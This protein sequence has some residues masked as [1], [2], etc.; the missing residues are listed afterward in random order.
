M[1]LKQFDGKC[2][3]I[4]DRDGIVFDGFCSFNSDEYNEHEYGRCEDGLQIANFLFY[5]SDIKEIRSLEDHFGEYGHFLDPF[6]KLEEFTVEDGIDSIRDILLSED[7]EHV[8]RLLRCI[9]Q[10]LGPPAKSGLPDREELTEV[11]KELLDSNDD[12]AVQQT[13][14]EVA[15]LCV[16]NG[17]QGRG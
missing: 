4:K 17:P 16:A 14:G 5:E 9:K 8:I 2:I 13:A 7:N 3:R 15:M 12:A 11:I 1:N 10:L 6:G